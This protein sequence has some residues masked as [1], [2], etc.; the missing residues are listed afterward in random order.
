MVQAVISHVAFELDEDGPKIVLQA[1]DLDFDFEVGLHPGP[2]EGY[3][4]LSHD[5]VEIRAVIHPDAHQEIVRALGKEV[6]ERR[7]RFFVEAET[8]SLGPDSLDLGPE[9]RESLT[10]LVVRIDTVSHRLF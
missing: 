3:A 8:E 9:P 5:E 7:P 6:A 2:A 4:I 10:R 1:F